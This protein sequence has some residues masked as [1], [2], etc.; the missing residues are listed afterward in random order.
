MIYDNIKME[1]FFT[2]LPD[3][4]ILEEILDIFNLNICKT[5]KR[6]YNYYSKYL[7]WKKLYYKYYD[8]S[9]MYDTKSY[10]ET[11]KL[12]YYLNHLIKKLNLKNSIYDFI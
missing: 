2:L 3:D 10:Y 5:N 1:G 11:F 6:Y 8:H 12:C 4:I 7:L 9:Q